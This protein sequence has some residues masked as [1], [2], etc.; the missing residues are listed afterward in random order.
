MLLLY[1]FFLLLYALAI[2]I[3]SLFNEKAKKWV[4]GRK[5]ILRKIKSALPHDEPRI[6]IHCASLGEFEQGRPVIEALK[7]EHPQYKILLSFFSPSGYELRKNYELADYVFYLPLDGRRRSAAFIRAVNPSLAVF[8]KYEFWYYYICQLRYYKVPSVLISAAFRPSQ[9]F[10]KEYGG[11]FRKILKDFSFL[12]VQNESS[13]ELLSGIGIYKNVAVSGDTRYDRVSRIAAQSKSFPLIEEWKG[14]SRL[15]IAGSTW[16]DDEKILCDLLPLLPPGWKMILAPH[17]IHTRHLQ[18][19]KELFGD[20]ALFYSAL[21]HDDHVK[22][23]PLWNR[24]QLLIIDNIGILSSLY[25]YGSVAFVG[26]GWTKGGIHNTLEPAVFGLPVIFGPNYEKF[27]EAVQ[28]VEYGYGF[29]VENAEE[30]KKV[31]LQ[32][33]M[34][35]KK[36]QYIQES[37]KDYMQQQTGATEKILEII[38][39]KYLNQ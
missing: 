18:E 27:A 9:L 39:E 5:D 4:S 12:F 26:G 7:K 2:R 25:R 31:L 15:L 37:L 22:Q 17:E 29:S 28:L 1:N 36:L 13:K 10:F 20:K 38:G 33:L 35:E 30:A 23:N 21:E 24:N 14:N 19:V 6:W 32:W 8:V 16:P 34:D 3:S 11:L